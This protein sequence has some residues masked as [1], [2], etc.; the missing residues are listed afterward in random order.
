MA[1]NTNTSKSVNKLSEAMA[2]SIAYTQKNMTKLLAK[3]G[4]KD[5]AKVEMIKT[6][7]PMVPGSKDDVEFVGMNGMPF[8]FK[9]GESVELPKPLFDILHDCGKI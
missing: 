5:A 4:V 6:Y 8:Y 1:L 9:R 3:A 2:E 7:I